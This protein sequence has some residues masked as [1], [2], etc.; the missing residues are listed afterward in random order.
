MARIKDTSV[1]AVKA[2]A[3]FVAV[4]EDRTSLRKQGARLVGRC[5][6]HEERTPSFSVNP[7]QGLFYCF[8][9]HKGG[10]MIT[11]VRETQGLDF[12]GAIE[13]L[14]ERFRIPLEYEDVSPEQAAQRDR[15]SRLY[16]LLDQAV[17]F[18]ERVL[19]ETEVG[20]FARDYLKG[21]GLGEAV[22]KEFRLGLSLE[23][24]S[25]TRK[26]LAK[27]FK[28]EELA[29]TGLTRARGEDYF[30]RRL[31]FPLTDARGRVVGFQ[32]R[33]IYE[34]DPLPGKYVNTQ[35]SELFHKSRVVYGLDKARTAIAREDR[36][37]VVEGNTDVI[38]LRQAGVGAVVA[39]MGTALT[40]PQL[41]ELG[42]L[43]KR[44]WLAFDGD[45]AGSSATLRGMELAMNQGFDV[46][47]VDL[48]QGKDPAEVA[49]DFMDHVAKARS[50]ASHLVRTQV[51]QALDEREALARARDAISRFEKGSNDWLAAVEAAQAQLNLP[52]EVVRTLAGTAFLGG[53]EID[54]RANRS[55]WRSEKLALGAAL[56]FPELIPLIEALPESTFGDLTL[57]RIRDWLV[58]GQQDHSVD[59]N[60]LAELDALIDSDAVGEETG[61]EVIL[62]LTEREIRRELRLASVERREVL[63]D[64]LNRILTEVQRYG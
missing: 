9:C 4:V 42:R 15:R 11:F 21:R 25:L 16:D 30:Q 46:R 59:K 5:P 10:D 53:E 41:N 36:A 35:E 56:R 7:G 13:W 34:D 55:A 38:A 14:A 43:T 22:A 32:A 51:S 60:D 48:P 44:L 19:W 39:S 63:T 1:E 61:R 20:S 37:I 58:S 23:G 47:I 26:A 64:A 8:G 24:N 52:P 45:A 49:A 27:G 40:E 2:G 50:F 28:R 29:A 17:S 57:R 3:D 6:F 33:K 54:A 18:Y 31:M 12:A 62:R